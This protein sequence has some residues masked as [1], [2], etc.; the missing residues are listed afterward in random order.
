M[1]KGEQPSDPNDYSGFNI[2]TNQTMAGFFITNITVTG[3][4]INGRAIS[5]YKV[6]IYTI[7][8]NGTIKPVGGGLV[9]YRFYQRRKYKQHFDN[10]MGEP[11]QEFKWLIRLDYHSHEFMAKEII[12]IK[13]DLETTCWN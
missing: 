4:D 12:E 9:R 13:F 11:T 2:S 7:E 8:P 6:R 10:Q 5:D 3:K 1:F